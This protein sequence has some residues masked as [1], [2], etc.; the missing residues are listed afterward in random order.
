MP[1]ST[2][3]SPHPG[4]PAPAGLLG[5]PTGGRTA[6]PPHGRRSQGPVKSCRRSIATRGRA[7]RSLIVGLAALAA[8]AA[9]GGTL[10]RR[11]LD[12][13]KDPSQPDLP[14]IQRPAAAAAGVITDPDVPTAGVSSSRLA[15]I[16]ADGPAGRSV[17]ALA[18]PFTT[19]DIGPMAEVKMGVLA[20]ELVRQ[21][22]LIAARDE[23]GLETRDEVL[24][25]PPPAGDQ[26]EEV[27]VV[28]A[29]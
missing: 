19:L 5:P 8:I 1:A 9:S 13:H 4:R 3:T 25:D 11:F 18:D 14:E 29:L 28:T 16:R 12:R 23:L 27:R 22:V 15:I 24:G 7:T 21:A 20:R 26:G 2:V 10:Y 17:V 6:G